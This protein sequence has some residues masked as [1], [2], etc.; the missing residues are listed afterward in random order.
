MKE[1]K[2]T[3]IFNTWFSTEYETLVGFIRSRYFKDSAYRYDTSAQEFCNDVFIAMSRYLEKNEL[4][5]N[6]KSLFD[7][8][9][10]NLFLSRVRTHK[11]RQELLKNYEHISSKE[12]PSFEDYQELLA[13]EHGLEVKM[14][15]DGCSISK[16]AKA[17]DS[18][19]YKTRQMIG[20]G[21]CIVKNI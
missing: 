6:F 17:T 16:I 14:L 5:T 18:Y 8:V 13:I 2:I 7:T 21:L 10:K 12:A 20:E 15:Q 19:F 1:M 11:R 9:S 3:E 4:K